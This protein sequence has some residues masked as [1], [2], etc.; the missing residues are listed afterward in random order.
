MHRPL[1]LCNDQWLCMHGKKVEEVE[2]SLLSLNGTPSPCATY[3]YSEPFRPR[4]CS[5][6]MAESNKKMGKSH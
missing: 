6:E 2:L 1:I 3:D 4:I 5:A